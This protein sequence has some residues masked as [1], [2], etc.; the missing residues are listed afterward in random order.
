MKR[1]SWQST[2]SRDAAPQEKDILDPGKATLH[3]TPEKILS[4]NIQRASA[5]SHRA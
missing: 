5:R 4:M 2:S 3:Q 1:A